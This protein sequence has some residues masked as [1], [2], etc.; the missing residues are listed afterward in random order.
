MTPS[1]MQLNR[2]NLLALGGAAAATLAAG[3]LA[4]PAAARA[5]L[6]GV[7]L[8]KHWRYKLGAFEIT[9]I[10]DSEAFIDGPYPI[11][12]KNAEE[13]DV[14]ALMRTNL[15][16][17]T[18]YQPGFSPTV[19]NTGK[20]LVLFDTG[21]GATGFVPRPNGGWLVDQLGPAGFKS[22]DIDVVVL[23]HGHP[24]HVAGIMENGKPLC[25]N[26]RYVICGAEYDYWA[27]AN[28]HTGELESLAAVFRANALPV[29]EKFTMIKPGDDVV[30]GI[31]SLAA[32]GHTPGHLAFVIESEG[33]Q[34]LFWGDCAHHH[35]ASLARPD[36]HCVFDIDKEQAVA[37]R[38]TIYE[39]AA[40]ERWPVIGYHMPFPSIGYVE[41]RP[42]GG[43]RWVEHSFQLYP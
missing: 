14:R 22:E 43:Y 21:N 5:P 39:M 13:A 40:T 12:G 23:S 26:A 16:P 38:K 24:D 9:T 25:P 2:R 33:K 20:H 4:N 8:A 6:L 34:M 28:K 10:M 15:V 36:W 18:R 1:K 7:S 27:P 31:R 42:T 3:S 29:A 30:P 19:I 41:R 37:T 11:I 32:H 35:V 17:E